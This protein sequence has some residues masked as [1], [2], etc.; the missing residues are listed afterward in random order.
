ML[1]IPWY[2]SVDDTITS[3]LPLLFRPEGLY[4]ISVLLLADLAFLIR[5]VWQGY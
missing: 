2:L 1:L 4:V 3:L 5:Y